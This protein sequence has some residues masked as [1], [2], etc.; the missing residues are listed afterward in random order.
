MISSFQLIHSQTYSFSLKRRIV[1]LD[2]DTLEGL[3]RTTIA[4]TRYRGTITIEFPLTFS[5]VVVQQ[6]EVK[7]SFKDIFYWSLQPPAKKDPTKRYD[8]VDVIWPFANFPPNE[9]D[10]RCAVQS[11]QDWWASWK[12]AVRNAVLRKRHGH[13]TSED[14]MDVAMGIEA[15]EPKKDWGATK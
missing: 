5:E 14:C 2:K 8:C 10:R 4:K 13:V 12:G 3:I 11:E 7:T 15:P 6:G 9:P 1:N